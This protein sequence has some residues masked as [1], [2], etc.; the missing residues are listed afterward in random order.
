LYQSII[1]SDTVGYSAY[2]AECDTD[3]NGRYGEVHTT[4]RFLKKRSA[5][6]RMHFIAHSLDWNVDWRRTEDRS[7]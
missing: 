5:Y 1:N 2:L 7:L 4:R 3:V 6:D